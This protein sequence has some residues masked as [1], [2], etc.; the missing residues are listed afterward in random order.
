MYATDPLTDKGRQMLALIQEYQKTGGTI[1]D[2]CRGRQL[3]SAAFH[4]WKRRLKKHLSDRSFAD[5]P[6]FVQVTHPASAMIP[7]V[8]GGRIELSFPDGRVI[9]FP[10]DYP[11]AD[12]IAVLRGNACQ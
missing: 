11:A 7:L 12:L 1:V 10:R 6:R 8:G 2:F 4:W 5:P 9:G 3:T